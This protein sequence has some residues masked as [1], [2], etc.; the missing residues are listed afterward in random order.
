MLAI[1]KK[2]SEHTVPC[3]L[4]GMGP[5]SC[6]PVRLPMIINVHS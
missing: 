1:I 4:L 3:T 2:V 6:R 5:S